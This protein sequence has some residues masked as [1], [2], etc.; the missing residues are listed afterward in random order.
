MEYYVNKG[1]LTRHS[2][3][4]LIG[5]PEKRPKVHTAECVFLPKNVKSNKNFARLGKCL[6]CANAINKAKLAL[7]KAKRPGSNLVRGCFHCCRNCFISTQRSKKI[8]SSK[9]SSPQIG[10]KGRASKSKKTPSSKTP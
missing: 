5:H 8:P 1:Y 10:V 4:Y 3:A 6:N 2:Q 7:K 9:I